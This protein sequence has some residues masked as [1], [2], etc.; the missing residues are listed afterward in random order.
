LLVGISA[1]GLALRGNPAWHGWRWFCW[2]PAILLVIAFTSLGMPGDTS[3]YVFLVV[4]FGWF[5]PMGLR[6]LQL[7]REP[8]SEGVDAG[9]TVP[10]AA[11]P[12]LL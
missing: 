12:G 2:T 7:L 3:W 9:R 11:S 6:L 10:S 4:G 8:R 5:T 1:S